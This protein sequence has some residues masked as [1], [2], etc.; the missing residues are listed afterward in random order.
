MK[1][2]DICQFVSLQFRKEEQSDKCREEVRTKKNGMSV[3]FECERPK[4]TIS[5]FIMVNTTERKQLKSLDKIDH[6]RQSDIVNCLKSPI[7]ADSRL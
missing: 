4:T 3:Q 7:R 5:F 1:E 6:K 2:D